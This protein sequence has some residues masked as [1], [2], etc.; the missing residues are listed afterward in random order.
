LEGPWRGGEEAVEGALVPGLHEASVYGVYVLFSF[1]G[2]EA[3]DVG[4]EVPE[5]GFGEAGP[6][7]LEEF[8]HDADGR[9]DEHRAITQES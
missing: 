2:D 6:E 7:L 9:W 5:L 8:L 3:E 4:G 1:A